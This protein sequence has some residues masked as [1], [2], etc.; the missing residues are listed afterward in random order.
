M[1]VCAEKLKDAFTDRFPY[2]TLSRNDNSR[3]NQ[4]INE[5]ANESK[6]PDKRIAHKING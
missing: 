1:G 4:D 3:F 6:R 2:S 5:Q